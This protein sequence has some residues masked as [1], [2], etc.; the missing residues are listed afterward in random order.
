MGGL[1]DELLKAI[2][3]AFTAL[4]LDRSGKVSK[5]QLKV[6]PL[7]ALPVGHG[8]RGGVCREGCLGMWR[9]GGPHCASGLRAVRGGGRAPAAPATAEVRSKRRRGT[10]RASPCDGLSGGPGASDSPLGR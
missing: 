5:S 7:P 3:H 9:G 6:S 8:T 10:R 1:K 4:D 2:W